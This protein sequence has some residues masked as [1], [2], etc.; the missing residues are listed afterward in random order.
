MA[1]GSRSFAERE[2]GMAEFGMRR[3][4]S[5]SLFR[6]GW[7]IIG[8]AGTGIYLF[9]GDKGIHG[10]VPALLFSFPWGFGLAVAFYNIRKWLARN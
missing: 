9:A 3:M 2:S 1:F 6:A 10:V 7:L 8:W 4:L 5:G